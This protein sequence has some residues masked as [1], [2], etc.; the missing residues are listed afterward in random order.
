M[1]L[2]YEQYPHTD[3]IST[4]ALGGGVSERSWGCGQ[5]GTGRGGHQGLVH[6]LGHHDVGGALLALRR[7]WRAGRPPRGGG[8]RGRARGQ[9]RP[10]ETGPNGVRALPP[11]GNAVTPAALGIS[12]FWTLGMGFGVWGWGVGVGGLGLGI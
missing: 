8:G 6:V 7:G 2:K 4:R 5:I 9:P 10:R 3:R 11:P 12:W 1:S